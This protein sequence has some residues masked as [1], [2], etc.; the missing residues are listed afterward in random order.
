MY[1]VSEINTKIISAIKIVLDS[2]RPAKLKTLTYS[3]QK[4]AIDILMLD[5]VFKNTVETEAKQEGLTIVEYVAVLVA[6]AIIMETGGKLKGSIGEQAIESLLNDRGVSFVREKTFSGMRDDGPL[7]I[8]FFI[9]E[10]NIAIEYQGAQHFE[11]VDYF[12]GIEALIKT[13]RRDSIKRQY[14]HDNGIRIEY[15]NHDQDIEKTLEA[16]LQSLVA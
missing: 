2:D 15:I 16:I 5:Q 4:T 8:D 13:R 7:R 10:M 11:P 3:Q 6:T 12:G 14:C 1:S 9:P